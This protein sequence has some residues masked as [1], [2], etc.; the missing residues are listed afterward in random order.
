MAILTK[1]LFVRL[2]LLLA[3]IGSVQAEFNIIEELAKLP[4]CGLNCF[5]DVI[6]TSSSCGY[7]ATC[8]CS[9]NN[10]HTTAQA[11]IVNKCNST[12]A[13]E[14]AKIEAR[15]CDRPY[16]NRRYQMLLPLI[17]EGPAWVSPW[18]RLYSR[19]LT[20][21]QWETDDYI[22]LVVGAIYTAYL[23]C[24][25]YT[26]QLAFG[27]D[28]WN[29]NYD[30][31]IT[32]LKFF[33]VS[34]ILY[35][36]AL[37][38]CKVSI[39]VFYLRIFNDKTFRIASYATLGVVVFPSIVM[40]FVQIFQCRPLE[41][42]WLGWRLQFYR[43]Q[44][45][46]IHT[47]VYIA[48]GLSI[49]QDV[50]IIALPL[51]SIFKLKVDTRAK[52]GI[53]VMFN[54][55]VLVVITSSIRLRFL[56]MF[57]RSANPT[58][59]YTDVLNWTGIELAIAIIVCCLPAVAV[60]VKRLIPGFLTFHSSRMSPL[61]SRYLRSHTKDHTESQEELGIELGGRMHP[62]VGVETHVT[63]DRTSRDSDSARTK[64]IGNL[65]GITVTRTVTTTTRSFDEIR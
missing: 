57:G 24:A 10:F 60:L 27:V 18:I 56:A 49:F 22:M 5:V 37:G 36:V 9:D 53:F 2:A 3:W 52:W 13:L 26:G 16:R 39:V 62:A 32:A 17:A 64:A 25:K 4:S 47:L 8:I 61:Q 50:V 19:W 45:M 65:M 46:D 51:P 54:L 21:G 30:Q 35:L 41:L 29:Q 23:A 1:Q 11:C 12:D 28:M 43:D 40:V 6:K 44:C 34:E 42:V 58:W 63:K 7:N 31:I 14:V 48:A 20:I 33:Y 15:A 59:D 55:G 38:L